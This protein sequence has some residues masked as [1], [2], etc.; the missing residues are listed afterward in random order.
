MEIGGD[1]IIKRAE[2]P[3]Q[4]LINV[5]QNMDY[6]KLMIQY[7]ERYSREVS[8]KKREVLE[9]KIR[10]M[11]GC[12]DFWFCDVYKKQ[13]VKDFIKTNLCRDKFCSNCKKVTQAARMAKYCP[14]LE[15]YSDASFHLVL[16]SPNVKGER[17]KDHI[18]H[19]AKCFRKLHLY[20]SGKKLIRGLSFDSWGLVGAIRSLE[21]TFKGDSY[22]PHYHVILIL[23]GLRHLNKTITNDYSYNYCRMKNKF[24][25]QEI[26]LQKIWYLLI[27]NIKVTMQNIH[28]LK[29]GYS[30]KMDKLKEGDYNEIFKYITKDFARDGSLM[31]YDNFKTLYE[32]LY[33]VKQIQGYGVLFSVSDSLDLES[34]VEAYERL[35]ADLNEKENPEHVGET[36]QDL[37]N[38]NEYTLI[39]RK[40]YMKYLREIEG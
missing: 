22:H 40:T 7:Y 1:L 9:N 15:K 31:T 20:L 34:M 33:R 24:S 14:E 27:N 12:N 18:K 35:V 5:L 38:D 25:D 32:S 17:L 13:K 28:N 19:M 37:L 10:Y 30:C 3:K 6:T 36:V 39:S 8:G 21:I 26:L 16:T 23:K 11:K 2:I 29:Q 4:T